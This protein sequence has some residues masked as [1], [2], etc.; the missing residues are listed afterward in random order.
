[1]TMAT[2]EDQLTRLAERGPT[3]DSRFVVR[4]A[5]QIAAD[6]DPA[7]DGG[8][9]RRT[10]VHASGSTFGP[11]G[12]R[13]PRA[14]LFHRSL[15]PSPGRH[16][17]VRPVSVAAAIAL[18]AAGLAGLVHLRA[19]TGSPPSPV[20]SVPGPLDP[21][22]GSLLTTPVPSDVQPLVSMAR[23]GWTV[24]GF[25]GFQPV[26]PRGPSATCPGCGAQRLVLAADGP[27]PGGALFTAWT[28]AADYD[29]DRL[30][31]PV[32]IGAVGGRA[33]SRGS[34]TPTAEN[35]MTI[36]WPLGPGRTAF[37]DATG[38]SDAQVI[39]LA[40]SLTF[41]ADVPVMPARPP[42][43][44][45]VDAPAAATAVEA[46]VSLTDGRHGIELI[47][48][49]AGVSGLLDW[50]Y[51]GGHLMYRATQPRQVDGAAVAV[52][53]PPAGERPIVAQDVYWVAGGWGYTAVGH[54]FDS[55]A[56]FLAALA[57][58][59][60]TDH[61]TFSATTADL[62]PYPLDGFTSPTG[63]TSEAAGS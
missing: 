1:M 32:S 52:D 47:A 40:T 36:A 11:A 57:D 34:G 50:R 39:E 49:N 31:T 43:F 30:D 3:V 20:A 42:G 9:S 62:A 26:A 37:V 44:H 46:F 51:P 12:G 56:D 35:R 23:P 5:T 27:Q 21:V 41:D 14:S 15:R 48:T 18:V 10:P 60:L 59:R 25:S 45:L 53:L 8:R 55:E 19:R 58:L 13:A 61:A 63:W 4:R 29:L 24:D 2:L 17:W 38:M 28:I 33:N 54:L 6:A 16:R 7:R 22:G